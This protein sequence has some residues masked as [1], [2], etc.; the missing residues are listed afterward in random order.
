MNAIGFLEIE[1]VCFGLCYSGIYRLGRDHIN[2]RLIMILVF[3]MFLGV[4]LQSYPVFAEVGGTY[5]LSSTTPV[6]ESLKLQHYTLS[7]GLQ[8]AVVEDQTRPVATVQMFFRV[9][10]GD[11]P[12]KRQGLAHLVEHLVGEAVLFG[13]LDL[14]VGHHSNAM[15]MHDLTHYYVTVPKYLLSETLMAFTNGLNAID[16]T[17]EKFDSEKE[18]VVAESIRRHD[19]AEYWIIKKMYAQVFDG[20]P[21]QYPIGGVHEDTLRA[22]SLNEAKAFQTR[23]YVP[24][25]ACLVVV[26]DVVAS[27]VL[28]EI[29]ELF[30]TYLPGQR[31][32]RNLEFEPSFKRT[33][34]D[35]VIYLPHARGT[36]VWS[37]W[38]L[39]S[40]MHVDQAAIALLLKVLVGG[41]NAPINQALV[42]NNILLRSR[43]G[44]HSHRDAGVFFLKGVLASHVS[45]EQAQQ[46]LLSVVQQVADSISDDRLH[47]VR[48]MVRIDLYKMVTNQ[49]HLANTIGFG[50]GKANDPAFYIQQMQALSYVS[51]A[52]ILQAARTYLIDQPMRQFILTDKSLTTR[53]TFGE[54]AIPTALVVLAFFGFRYYRRL[55][56]VQTMA[57]LLWGSGSTAWADIPNHA[58]Y[59]QCDPRVPLTEISI[60]YA[61][62][63]IT[64]TPAGKSGLPFVLEELVR[65]RLRIQLGA[66]LDRLGGGI[67]FLASDL[68]VTVKVRAFSENLQEVLSLVH[69][70]LTSLQ[71]T[72]GEVAQNRQVSIE[73]LEQYIAGTKDVA[74]LRNYLFA[75]QADRRIA[76]RQGIELVTALDLN[77]YVQQTLH[78]EV[79]YFKVISD[80]SKKEIT[81][82]V[83]IFTEAR[84]QDGFA[85]QPKRKRRHLQQTQLVI[86]PF[87]NAPINYCWTIVNALPRKDQH[88]FA[89]Q[90]MVDA[91]SQF[92]FYQLRSQNGWCYA[93]NAQI[94]DRFDPPVIQLFA[95]PPVENTEYVIPELHRI[96]RRFSEDPMFWHFLEKSRKHLKHAYALKYDLGL[97]LNQQ[98]EFDR[99]GIVPLSVSDYALA[100]DRVTRE[101]VT[102]VIRELFVPPGPYMPVGRLMV[103]WGSQKYL[104]PILSHQFSNEKIEMFYL[105]QLTEEAE[106]TIQGSLPTPP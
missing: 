78:A 82:C 48:N 52:D 65:D 57:L 69:G 23:Y 62:G 47:M 27:D 85:P 64:R 101:D 105:E 41:A 37:A 92:L 93:A 12:P 34:T 90:V 9:G 44:F 28:R 63:G 104:E 58:I 94:L 14:Q 45:R 30:G 20:H 70:F 25:N 98:I 18:V 68:D 40:A 59:Y 46:A 7:N 6:L 13:K 26:G 99:D 54:V 53:V 55:W 50:F 3:Q 80:L 95:N 73:S 100:I 91:L 15:T 2:N 56:V 74:L 66:E 76:T 8:V 39:P 35:T 10:S 96:M 72:D 43:Y 16:V 5:S 102:D 67:H 81:Q 11:E 97:V 83:R 77:R 21:Y 4:L 71:F 106:A 33:S 29:A 1:Q 22:F 84:L 79:L 17:Q 19:D 49:Q 36:T 38:P 32:N 61:T 87:D 24:Q 75:L 31:N 103:Y 88:W 89:Q 51:K 60:I 86:V 42:D